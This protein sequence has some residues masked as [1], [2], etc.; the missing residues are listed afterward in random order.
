[1]SFGKNGSYTPR[2]PSPSNQDPVGANVSINFVSSPNPQTPPANQ[3]S[4]PELVKKV[5]IPTTSNGPQKP[6][7]TPS[8]KFIQRLFSWEPETETKCFPIFIF[9]LSRLSIPCPFHSFL[10]VMGAYNY[11]SVSH[12]Y[13]HTTFTA[14]RPIS[15]SPLTFV[16]SFTSFILIRRLLTL[17]KI[18]SHS[19]II[20]DCEF[21][22]KSGKLSLDPFIY[23]QN[24]FF[25]KNTE[26]FPFFV[27]FTC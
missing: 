11:L 20:F 13:F 14:P 27:A 1:M 17:I 16:V 26:N 15:S 10:L 6:H 2:K 22:Y 21:Q 3:P 25:S 8:R 18:S 9:C 4:T 23:I 12:G 7:R 24:V 19:N 5:P